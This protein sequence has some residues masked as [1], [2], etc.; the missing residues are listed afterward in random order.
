[1]TTNQ[2]D[3]STK[4]ISLAPSDNQ[5]S[6]AECLDISRRSGYSTLTD[7]EIDALFEYRENM[8]KMEAYNELRSE[9]VAQSNENTSSLLSTLVEQNRQLLDIANASNM[10]FEEVTFVG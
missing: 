6:V 8:V 1:M 5:R 3:Y 2:L 4:Y 7:D 10:T 9:L